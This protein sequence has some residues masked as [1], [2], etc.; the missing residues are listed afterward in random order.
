M[1]R[2][3]NGRVAKG[4]IVCYCIFEMCQQVRYGGAADH[5]VDPHA[6]ISV[7]KDG[8]G[9]TVKAVH[10]LITVCTPGEREKTCIWVTKE[11][12]HLRYSGDQ[13]GSKCDPVNRNREGVV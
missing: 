1:K 6:F 13:G 8:Y 12:D 3:W 7:R 11:R 4:G 9:E 5:D 10:L 2:K